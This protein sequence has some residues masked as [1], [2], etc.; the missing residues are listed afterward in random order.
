MSIAVHYDALRNNPLQA[1]AWM[2][3]AREYADS[4]LTWQT[5]YMLRQALRIN[6]ELRPAADALL[7]VLPVTVDESV[8]LR[9]PDPKIGRELIAALEE[10]VERCPQDWLSWLYL[11]RLYELAGKAKKKIATALQQAQ[12]LELLAGETLHWIGLWSLRAGDAAAAVEVFSQLQTE[13]PQRFGSMIFL[14]DALMQTG[15]VE[16]AQV[17]FELASHSPN[18]S[19]LVLLADMLSRWSFRDQAIAV[20]ERVTALAPGDAAAWFALGAAQ[21]KAWQW[22]R[23]RASLENAQKLAPDDQDITIMLSQLS[24]WVGDMHSQL[25][26]L[27]DMYKVE[28]KPE[29]R[30]VSTIAMS[31]LYY[32]A[33]LPAKVARL[34]RQLCAP[35]EQALPR[36]RL[37][38][39]DK[40]SG[41]R[42]RIAYVTGDL[43]GQHPVQQLIFP[44]LKQHDKA[45][46]E[47]AVYY[48]GGVQDS[49]TQQA[50]ALCERWVDAA[51]IDDATLQNQII[52]DGVD[53][54]IDL[55]GHT[56]SHRL[57][58]FAMGAAPVQ[59]SFLG[60]P[61][62]TG[63]QSINWLVADRVVAPDEHAAL[64]S[65]KVARL[66]D[67]VFCWAPQQDFAL[68]AAKPEA[69]PVLFGSFNHSIKLSP[70]TIALWAKVLLAVPDS[71]LL[72]K[73]PVLGDAAACEYFVAAFGKHGV[74]PARIALQGPSDFNDLMQAYSVVDIALDPVPYNG[75]ITTL[76]ALW[77]G[78]PVVT[79]QGG[80]FQGR[81]GA[82]ILNALGQN[83]WVAQDTKSYVKAAQQLAKSVA[84]LRQQRP[85][86]R[87]QMQD[88]P[89]CNVAAYTTH[90][91][92]LYENM[93]DEWVEK[94]A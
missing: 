66:P 44:V 78:V 47:L 50:K 39:N 37:F 5:L 52:S 18:P 83:D 89:L 6:A 2:A 65:E 93:W 77:M 46:F 90:L 51:T 70:T 81:M 28:G 55:A 91:E 14:A 64:F 32:D 20:R 38:A 12:S 25:K 60:Y 36:K 30:L 67:C 19:V 3:L 49:F 75:G 63:M 26:V 7:A 80:S 31:L 15:D 87:K 42:L 4:A 29:S 73:A 45:R 85:M 84:K 35:I 69:A 88:S 11:A 43:H 40:T 17:V 24:S 16:R 21:H 79:L 8:L 23:A 54:L 41:R 33:W 56:D 61:H 92:A 34:H 57:G 58:V 9:L 94:E 62:S 48:T 10:V 22:S 13:Y 74:A 72:L 71:R 27:S 68:P 59:V 76:Q 1:E 82:S 53:I 86:L